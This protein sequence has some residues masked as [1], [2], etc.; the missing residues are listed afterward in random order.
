MSIRYPNDPIILLTVNR[1]V[2]DKMNKLFKDYCKQLE[3]DDISN[4][5]IDTIYNY[6]K[7]MIQNPN[8]FDNKDSFSL[9]SVDPKTQNILIGESIEEVK[10]KYPDSNLWNRNYNFFLAEINWIEANLI[11]NKES[12]GFVNRVGRKQ[13]P[14]IKNHKPKRKNEL[15]DVMYEV[16][17]HYIKKIHKKNKIFDFGTIYWQYSKINIPNNEKP[18]FII[19]DEVQDVSK[20]MFYVLN[21]FISDNGHWTV[22]GD[23]SQNI[24]GQNFSWKDMGLKI[25]KKFSLKINYRNNKQIGS[26]AKSVLST[27]YFDKT[28]KDFVKPHLYN[29]PD[30]EIPIRMK[31]TDYNI[32]LLS[33]A[34]LRNINNYNNS[35]AIITMN[36]KDIIEIKAKL[37]KYISLDYLNNISLL[38]INKVK[39]MEYDKVIIYC[40]DSISY[41]FNQENRKEIVNEEDRTVNVDNLDSFQNESISEHLN[42]ARRLYVSLT[43]ARKSLVLVYKNNPMQFVFPNEKLIN[44]FGG[45]NDS[46]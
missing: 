15:R 29:N 3:I 19:L 1:E 28:S 43:R 12:Y 21:H 13:S 39:G 26:L 22:L 23:L 7:T 20:A 9:K 11:T 41:N 6:T 33:K 38:T 17:E 40:I 14:M 27:H 31:N 35:I 24:F 10:I 25:R 44:D 8:Y 36:S 46:H 16:F 32:Y 18:K 5:K 45:K 30:G 34:I 37:L 42:V 2:S 4:L